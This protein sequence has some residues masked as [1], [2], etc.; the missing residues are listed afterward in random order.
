LTQELG[1]AGSKTLKNLLTGQVM[2]KISGTLSKKLALDVIE[3]E[4]NKNWRDAR[5]LVGKYITNDLFLSIERD[6]SLNRSN[7]LAPKQVYLEY[8]I[9][10]FLFLQATRG[11]EK[12]TGFNLIWKLER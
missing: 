11:D 1:Q 8:E 4:G 12:T 9:T 3:F 10:R 7:E 5:V 2:G 6:F